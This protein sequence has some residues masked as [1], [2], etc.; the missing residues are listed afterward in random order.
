[1]PGEIYLANPI[2]PPRSR[3]GRQKGTETGSVTVSIELRTLT[4]TRM[5]IDGN[6]T[7]RE[8]REIIL[9]SSA[10][11]WPG[12]RRIAILALQR[13][14]GYAKELPHAERPGVEPHR[15]QSDGRRCIYL[16]EQAP[17]GIIPCHP[18]VREV[19][20]RDSEEGGRKQL[21][22]QGHQVYASPD[23]AS[24]AIYR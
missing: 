20:V 12:P 3:S 14:D 21:H 11:A 1:M 22:R 15:R 9:A 16:R 18:S 10:H 5:R 24:W 17:E 7:G 8:L 6:L 23:A 4:G 13:A 19:D 2:K